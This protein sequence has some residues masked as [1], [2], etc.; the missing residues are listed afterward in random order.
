M[1]FFVL[2]AGNSI[3]VEW[4]FGSFAV[5]NRPGRNRLLPGDTPSL[6]DRIFARGDFKM[7]KFGFGAK[8]VVFGKASI[9]RQLANNGRR[10]GERDR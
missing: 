9:G 6:K 3:A 5:I 7:R 1:K 4:H 2:V 10:R 8:A